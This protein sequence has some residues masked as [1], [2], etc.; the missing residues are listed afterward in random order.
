MY[1]EARYAHRHDAP[2]CSKS[3]D[4]RVEINEDSVSLSILCFEST[5]K[6]RYNLNIKLWDKINVTA[7]R[8][9]YQAVGR[10]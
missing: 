9:E 10:H 1:I 8:H 3:D 5:S 2:G 4:E 7:S 6:I